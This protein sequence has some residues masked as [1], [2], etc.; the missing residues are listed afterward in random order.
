MQKCKKKQVPKSTSR[1]PEQAMLL[2]RDKLTAFEHQEIFN[3]PVI[4]CM[5]LHANKHQVGGYDDDDGFYKVVPHD[6][7]AYRYEVLRT[8]GKGTFGQVVKAYDHK[9]HQHV[10]IKMVRNDRRFSQEAKEEIKML[11]MLK[12]LDKEN[13]MNV[14]H[15]LESFSFRNHMCMTFELLGPNL[16]DQLGENKYRGLSLSTV[17]KLAV[18][19]LRCLDMLHKNK[20]MHCDL[21]P[22]NIALKTAGSSGIKVIDFGASVYDHQDFFTYIQTRYYRAPEVLLGNRCGTPIDMWSFGCI[23]AE[24]LTG[25]PLFYGESSD[26]QMACIIEVLG[27]P[28]REL[29]N[30][31]KRGAHFVSA[32]GYPLYCTDKWRKG[33]FSPSGIFRG[34]PGSRKLPSALKGRGDLKFL[35]FLRRCLQWDPATRMTPSEALNHPWLKNG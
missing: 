24:L 26:D 25:S 6:H 7:I 33:G 28:P 8:L 13:K 34:S 15:L 10:A 14:V 4:Y 5:G 31:S 12:Q 32:T 18:E 9:T 29:L 17:R 23:L 16:Y 19:I 35:N 22:E 30:T 3:Y 21:K 2:Y 11:K 27:M 20:I 1:T